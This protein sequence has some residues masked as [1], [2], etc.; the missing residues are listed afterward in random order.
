VP[1]PPAVTSEFA[2]GDSTQTVAERGY[3]FVPV[4]QFSVD[5]TQ[6]AFAKAC[7]SEVTHNLV[8]ID[9]KLACATDQPA[10][11]LTPWYWVDAPGGLSYLASRLRQTCGLEAAT[12]VRSPPAIEPSGG[13]EGEP[14]ATGV[15]A[16]GDVDQAQGG[17]AFGR[18]MAE[19]AK[20]GAVAGGKTLLGITLLVFAWPALLAAGAAVAAA[21]SHSDAMAQQVETHA[22]EFSL[23]A[24]AEDV[25]KALG[26]PA[27]QFRLPAG[28][29][30]VLGFGVGTSHVLYVGICDGQAVWIH[31][32]DSW[33]QMLEQ[34]AKEE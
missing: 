14:Q 8:F 2:V 15:D 29:T 11:E 26:S 28:D 16:Q 27:V 22:Y 7:S 4:Y 33:L 19:V 1:P 25:R 10:E 30:N 21:D 6:Y 23:P 24:P 5:G 31:G 3:R 12:E 17:V 9:T 13:N 18:D 34:N 32:P 20:Q